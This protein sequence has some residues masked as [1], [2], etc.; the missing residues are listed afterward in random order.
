MEKETHKSKVESRHQFYKRSH[1]SAST[2]RSNQN[3]TG[4]TQPI[5]INTVCCETSLKRK[6]NFQ[7]KE[8][9]SVCTALQVQDGRSGYGT[10][11]HSTRRLHDEVRPPG[12]LFLSANS[13]QLQTL[14]T[15]H[16]SGNNIRIPVPPIRAV[17]CTLDIHQAIETSH[18][19][20]AIAGNTNCNISGRYAHFGSESRQIGLGVSQHCECAKTTGLSYQAGKMLPSSNTTHRISGFLDQLHRHAAS[21]TERE[22]PKHSGRMQE[23]IPESFYVNDRVVSP[24]RQNDPLHTNGTGTGSIALPCTTATAHKHTA[25]P[26]DKLPE[27]DQD[28]L[29]KG[30]VNRPPMVDLTSDNSIQQHSINP[31][32]IRYGHIHGCI[33][34]GMGGPM[35]WNIDGGTLDSPGIQEPHQ[36]SRVKSCP[37]GHQVLSSHSNTEATAHQSTDGQFYSCCL[38]QQERRNQVINAGGVSGRAMGSLPSEQYMDNSTT[39]SWNSEYRCG[40]GLTS[41]QRTHGMDSGQVNFHTYSK[42]ILHSTSRSVCISTESPATKICVTAPRSRGDECGCNDLA[43]EQMDIIHS[44]PNSNATSHPEED[45][46]G[47]VELSAHCP[48]LAGTDMVSTPA[49]VVDRHP[50]DFA[51][52]GAHNISTIQPASQASTLANAETRGMAAF[53]GRCEAEGLPPQVCDILMAS[54]RDGT[55]KRYEGPWKL[56][57]SWCLS[58]NTYPFSATITEVLLFLAE[59]FNQRNLSY[60]TIGVY[61][62]CISQLHDPVG[63]Q[64]LGTLPLL[65]RFMKGIFELR[66]PTPKVCSTWSVKT[67][68][69]YLN[70]LESNAKLS[71]KDLTLKTTI[72]LALTSST[73]A[74]ELAAL[75]LD[76]ISKK[77]HS[78]EFTIPQ[79]VKNSRPNHPPRKLFLPSFPENRNLCVIESLK[80]Y[81]MR[82]A[83]I[84]KDQNLLVSYATP[85]RAIGSQTVSRW[86]RTVL[87]TAGINSQ[88]TSHSTR[89]AATSA[90]ADNGVPIEDILAAADWSSETTFETFYHKPVS[91]DSFAKSILSSV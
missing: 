7:L 59:Q 34:T 56:W 89:S 79:H 51:N 29:I 20:A 62:S 18:F 70:S 52:V 9:E 63:G 39:P 27:Q 84:R 53:R 91:Q 55:K 28:F 26:E 58:R 61:K 11:G 83:L 6:T 48:K 24:S 17:Q 71:L 88:Y 68:L 12:R 74:H 14:S 90:A 44:P 67:L 69:Q 38:R 75:H 36:R 45:S 50:S 21:S 25:P 80:D 73:R 76:F 85:H 19:T 5:H 2:K 40:L 16:L 31:T 72:L 41:L 22:A 35:Q 4:T 54:W 43:M 30:L 65:S 23:G 42:K 81:T 77:E 60:R 78:W 66:P 86:I 64:P 82:T 57:T 15:V 33:H 46:G 8:F 1:F 13:R 37:T 49:A 87:L 3:C 10:Q 47:P 32:S